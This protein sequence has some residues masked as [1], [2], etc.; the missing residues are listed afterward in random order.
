M[1]IKFIFQY[2]SSKDDIV[3][4]F[5]VNFINIHS[6]NI[7]GVPTMSDNVLGNGDTAVNKYSIFTTS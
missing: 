1:F 6:A 3:I 4:K 2:L 5:L 7:Y